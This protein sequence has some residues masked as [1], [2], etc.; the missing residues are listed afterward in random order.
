MELTRELEDDVYRVY[1]DNRFIGLGIIKNKLLK[2]D[3]VI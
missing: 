2:R 1:T 3:I